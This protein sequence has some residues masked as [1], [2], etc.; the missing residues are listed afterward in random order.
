MYV[1]D[2][3]VG[4]WDLAPRDFVFG[5]DT[6]HIGPEGTTTKLRFEYLIRPG[7]NL[8]SFYYWVYTSR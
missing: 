3:F 4:D 8:N 5:E 1:E 7:T 6:F 2:K